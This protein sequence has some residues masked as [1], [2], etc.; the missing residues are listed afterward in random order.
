MPRNMPQTLCMLITT[1][2]ERPRQL[3]E[4]YRPRENLSNLKGRLPAQIW[5]QLA[6]ARGAHLNAMEGLPIFAAAMVRREFF[7]KMISTNDI[8]QLAGNLAK[9]PSSDLNTLSLEYIGAR[10]LYTALYMGAKSEAVSYLR[11]GVWAWSISIPIW[12]LIQAGRVLNKS[13]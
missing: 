10:L 1:L 5:Q 13:E 6:K 4:R 7:E 8:T 3:I 11:T 9:L 2:T 12:G